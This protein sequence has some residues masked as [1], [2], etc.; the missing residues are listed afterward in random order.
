MEPKIVVYGEDGATLRELPALEYE[1]VSKAQKESFKR[2]MES[3]K[4]SK[5]FVISVNKKVE[6]V[7]KLMSLQEA[8]AMF[9]IM[10]HLEFNSEGII[11]KEGQ[12]ITMTDLQKLLGK[13]KAQVSRLVNSLERLSLIFKEKQGK[14]TVI[15]VNEEF[16]F[17]GKVL[18]KEYVT[19]VYTVKARSI[20]KGL[21]LQE[22]GLLY[23]I[24]PFFHFE[25]MVL[26]NN[27][28]ERNPSK[29]EYLSL[30]E[31]AG[32]IGVD[33][34]TLTRLVPALVKKKAIM[35]AMTGNMSHI[36]V[37]PNLYFKMTSDSELSETIRLIFDMEEA[38]E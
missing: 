30:E 1:L 6:E 18:K 29:L 3:I 25:H 32:R 36:I 19:K 2:K 5:K 24:M 38:Q 37:N 22:L 7:S 27:P 14:S 26:C 20:M 16:H 31:L 4:N 34:T 33:R 11:I 8:G 13:S 17:I 21:E 28:E 15:R 12:P 10:I 35:K 9:S 23:K